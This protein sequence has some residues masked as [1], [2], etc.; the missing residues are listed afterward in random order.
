[1]FFWECDCNRQIFLSLPGIK[2]FSGTPKVLK[3][4][5]NDNEILALRKF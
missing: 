5:G 3:V 4:T 1:M 2:Y